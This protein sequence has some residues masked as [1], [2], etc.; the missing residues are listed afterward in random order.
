MTAT[1]HAAMHNDHRLWDSETC[2]WRDDIRAWQHELGAALKELSQLEE[3]FQKHNNLLQ[4]HAASIRLDEQESDAHEHALAEFEKG[5]E[6][7]ALVPLA[8]KHIDEAA[9]REKRREAHETLKRRHHEALSHWKALWKAL[10]KA[11][12]DAE[13]TTT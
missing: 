11:L 9:R 8:L 10:R 7:Q 12:A 2:A 1:T 3:A 13:P 6:G 5:G 4:R